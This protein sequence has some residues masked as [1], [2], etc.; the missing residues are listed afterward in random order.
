[1]QCT[2]GARSSEEPK[3]RMFVDET[4][5]DHGREEP[6][7]YYPLDDSGCS[8]ITQIPV[9]HSDGPPPRLGFPKSPCHSV[10]KYPLQY[11][12]KGAGSR[13]SCQADHGVWQRF[14]TKWAICPLAINSRFRPVWEII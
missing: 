6:L 14:T 13:P 2:R 10:K 3:A 9:G 7:T 4:T 1:M 12:G 8:F 11:L 5:Y